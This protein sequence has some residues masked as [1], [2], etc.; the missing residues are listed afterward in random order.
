MSWYSGLPSSSRNAAIQAFWLAAVGWADTMAIWPLLPMASASLT[1]P[2]RPTELVV[3]WLTKNGRASTAESAS[4]VMTL[5]P[6]RWARFIAGATALGSLG[7][8]A[9]AGTRRSARLL[10]MAI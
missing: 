1:A 4:N 2:N 7:A 10:M 9:M 6:M 5:E 3:A 8:T